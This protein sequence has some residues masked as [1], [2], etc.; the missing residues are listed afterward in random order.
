ML[1]AKDH[2]RLR[3]RSGNG[4]NKLGQAIEV[5]RVKGA[6]ECGAAHEDV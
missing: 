3:F 4:G 6:A 1:C 5:R 2:E